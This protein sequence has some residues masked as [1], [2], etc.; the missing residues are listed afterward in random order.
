MEIDARLAEF[1]ID[2]ILW[3][4]S[5]ILLLVATEE[6]G[7]SGETPSPMSVTSWIAAQH[8]SLNSYRMGTDVVEFFSKEVPDFRCT[9]DVLRK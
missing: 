8:Y 5:D 1:L 3:K 4:P 9:H 7:V 6:G 2:A